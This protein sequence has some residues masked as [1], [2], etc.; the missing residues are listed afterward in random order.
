VLVSILV[1]ILVILFLAFALR[2]PKEEQLITRRPYNNLYND[3]TAA[4]RDWLG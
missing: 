4:R 1:T 3:A 2:S